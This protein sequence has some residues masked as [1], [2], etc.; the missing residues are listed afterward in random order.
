VAAVALLKVSLLEVIED[1]QAWDL[2]ER[3]VEQVPQPH[4]EIDLILGQDLGGLDL[5]V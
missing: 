4:R 3:P 2:P 5:L 1:E